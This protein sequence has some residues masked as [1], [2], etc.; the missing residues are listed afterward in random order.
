MK[1][2]GSDV[3]AQ[4][5]HH[6]TTQRCHRKPHSTQRSID[7]ARMRT[8]LVATVLST[9]FKPFIAS[10]ASS[11]CNIRQRQRSSTCSRSMAMHASSIHAPRHTTP[12]CIA[13]HSTTR[14]LRQP[15]VQPLQRAPIASVVRYTFVVR[16][17]RRR[18]RR[19]RRR[20]SRRSCVRSFVRS[21]PW[22]ERA[23]ALSRA[24]SFKFV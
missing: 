23:N 14:M 5:W 20:Q 7:L 10:A 13:R 2:V 24:F 19:R 12:Q 4:P 1:C 6:K 17:R 9:H 21:F 18:Q 15:P 3:H 11:S 22:N 16:R 8:S